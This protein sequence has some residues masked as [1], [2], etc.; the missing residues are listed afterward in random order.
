MQCIINYIRAHIAFVRELSETC[1]SECISFS[2]NDKNKVNVGT[3]AVSRYHHIS[4]FCP[5][6]DA[7]NY[8][9]HDFPYANSTIIPSGYLHLLD[10][11]KPAS[12]RSCSLD[13][14]S[15]CIHKSICSSV[16]SGSRWRGIT[17]RRFD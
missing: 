14:S 1:A 7:P 17:F 16:E 9:D 5:P 6:D 13:R 15:T 2:C 4:R 10:K 11:I 12:R 8:F 3:L